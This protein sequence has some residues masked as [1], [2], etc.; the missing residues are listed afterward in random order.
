MRFSLSMVDPADGYGAELPGVVLFA[1]P[2][3]GQKKPENLGICLSSPPRDAVE[4]QENQE[5]AEQAAQEVERGRTETH[6]EEEEL[7]LRAE[8]RERTGQ[9]PMNQIDAPVDRHSHLTSADIH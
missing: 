3:R 4:H 2:C 1:K 6:R 9:R 5:P 7:S 8:N